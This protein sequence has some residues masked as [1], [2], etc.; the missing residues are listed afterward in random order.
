MPS[1]TARAAA[2]RRDRRRQ[3]ERLGRVQTAGDGNTGDRS[4]YDPAATQVGQAVR[5]QGDGQPELRRWVHDR[6]INVR[7]ARKGIESKDKHRWVIERTM[8]CSTVYSRLP[9]AT[10]AKPNTSSSSSYSE[11]A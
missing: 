3:Y 11:Q 4:L 2:G 1:P 6:G 9:C 7:I 8:A 5:R 10:N